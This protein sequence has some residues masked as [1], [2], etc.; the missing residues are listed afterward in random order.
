M[1]LS[2]VRIQNFRS[3]KD[4]EFRPSD[5]CALIGPNN[6]GKS[7]IL[8]AINL[9][10][11]SSWPTI[12]SVSEKDFFG[13]DETHDIVVTLWYDESQQRRGDVGDPI[14]FTGIQFK[15]MR[16][17]R[18]SGTHR[19]GD[20]RSELL[21]VDENGDPVEVLKVWRAGSKPS[22]T[23]ATVDQATRDR[24]PA[25]MVDIDRNASYHLSGS[26]WSILGRMLRDISKKL[27]ADKPRFAE[28]QTK[29]DEV[30]ELL[31]TDDFVAL[32]S[33]IV[34]QLEAHTGLTGIE[35]ALDSIDP[36]NLYKSFS[37]LFKDPETPEPVDSERM[38]SGI[39]SAVVISLLQ[40]YRELHK[41]NAILLFEEPELYLH[42][43][44]RRHLSRLLRELAEEGT[45]IIYTTHS[46]DFV[47]LER[48][49]CVR[50]V[51]RTLDDG[52]GIKQPTNIP[53]SSNWR[54]RLRQIRHF[55]SPRNEVFFAESVVLV[56]GVTEQ[57]AIPILGE[58]MPSPL[59]LDRLDCS[60]IEVGGKSSLPLF[61]K[62]MRALG[63]RVLVVYDTD[64]DQTNVQ[65]VATNE[66]RKR[67]IEDALAEDGRV[68]ECDPYFEELVG[69]DGKAK[70]DKEAKIREHLAGLIEWT[71]VPDRLQ[72]LMECV[73]A[74][75]ANDDVALDAAL[76]KEAVTVEAERNGE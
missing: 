29:L 28:F 44:G 13:Y 70:Q 66:R 12:R 71:D 56:E 24:L 41:E 69:V 2:R 27:K 60:V 53:L 75:A 34:E 17:K 42:P 59:D 48:I 50:L 45:Q 37:V 65:D 16:Y 10:L 5:L 49:D 61:I 31:H 51:S 26:Q 52:T 36:I 9:V 55:G 43:H 11:G 33:K 20:L 76:A 72:R 15:V 47:D 21:C 19:A 74:F 7:N 3:I 58:L 14:T 67:D 30:R 54:K 68:F 73:A 38:G 40:A 4:A 23:P 39:Q 1:R 32:Q 18:A 35:V 6:C 62:M 63:K 25:V 46:Q 64:S 57:A 8:K 22:P